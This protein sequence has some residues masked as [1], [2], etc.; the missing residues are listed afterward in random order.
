M[1]RLFLSH[2]QA[3]QET[4]P[5]LSMFTVHSGIPKA[6]NTWYN[7]CKSACVTTFKYLGSQVLEGPEDD[8]K[9]SKY[10]ALK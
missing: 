3:L 5:S 2:L 4:D 9:E 10:V 6:Y 1:F 8:S 7:Y